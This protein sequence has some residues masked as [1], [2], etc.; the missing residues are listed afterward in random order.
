MSEE[1]EEKQIQYVQVG[2]KISKDRIGFIELPKDVTPQEVK[3]F[4][5]QCKHIKVKN[6]NSVQ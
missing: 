4:I 6:V 1:I 2:V 5:K 3:N